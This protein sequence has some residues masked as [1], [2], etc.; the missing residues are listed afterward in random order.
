MYAALCERCSFYEEK[1]EKAITCFVICLLHLFIA[2]SLRHSSVPNLLERKPSLR[3]PETKISLPAERRA[4][5]TRGIPPSGIPTAA[6]NPPPRVSVQC[7]TNLCGRVHSWLKQGEKTPGG[8]GLRL[9]SWAFPH[10]EPP[11]SGLPKRSRI[12]H[13]KLFASPVLEWN[14]SERRQD[15]RS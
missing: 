5:G 8:E 2:V 12:K 10:A 9:C 15:H 1:S 7:S 6:S 13:P 11:L 14:H 3:N 4:W